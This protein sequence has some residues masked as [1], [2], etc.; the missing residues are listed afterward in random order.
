[1]EVQGYSSVALTTDY[2]FMNKMQEF[3]HTGQLVVGSS[4]SG[5]ISITIDTSSSEVW[6]T[7]VKINWKP[8]RVVSKHFGSTHLIGEQ[9]CR[10]VPV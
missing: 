4:M 8:L 2:L 3:V 6:L 1:M 5:C 7:N 10:R 9:K